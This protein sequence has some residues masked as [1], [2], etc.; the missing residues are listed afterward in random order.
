MSGRLEA[1]DSGI[2]FITEMLESVAAECGSGKPRGCLVMNTATEF[3]QNDPDI[4]RLVREGVEAFGAVF[5]QA[6]RRAQEEGD[7]PA[8]KDARVLAR[9]LVTNMSGLRT[10]AKAGMAEKDLEAT[11]RVVIEALCT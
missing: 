6:I 1:A 11:S 2:D 3:A 9:F 4:A 5:H 7:V 8:G 10:M